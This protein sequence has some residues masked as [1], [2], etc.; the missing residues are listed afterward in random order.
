MLKWL[1]SLLGFDVPST[2]VIAQEPKKEVKSH[3]S[4]VVKV[5]QTEPTAKPKKQAKKP[6]TKKAATV[7]LDSMKKNELLAHAKANGI[8]ANASMNKA[9]LIEAIKN[10]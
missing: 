3:V 5:E 4:K 8:K 2:P 10:G 1:K 6:A 9:A 7:D